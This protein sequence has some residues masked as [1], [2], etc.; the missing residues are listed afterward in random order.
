MLRK[1]YFRLSPRGR[2]V[3][4]RLYFLPGDIFRRFFTKHDKLIPP[5]GMTFVGSGNFELIGDNFFKHICSSTNISAN[6]LILEIGCGIGRIARPFTTFIQDT[7]KYT[8]FDILDYGIKWC[9]SKYRRFS[10]FSFEYYPLLNDLYNL[11]AKENAADFIFPYAEK[12]FDLI[13]LISVFT[14]MQKD[15]VENYINQISRVLKNEGYCYAS[16][17]LTDNHTKSDFFTHNFDA[18]SLHDLR[19][20]NANVAYNKDYI[21]N[22][23]SGAGLTP[24][25]VFP[26][27]W[28]GGNKEDAIDFQ[29]VIVFKKT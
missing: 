26:G 12:S 21:I 14:H 13:L 25:A 5:K 11:E 22:I 4:R 20:K 29:D 6:S 27:W 24:T 9:N 2:R 19:V 23:A 16:F 7:G 15:E 10:N 1:L 17:F 18:Y 3:A 28:S 8:G